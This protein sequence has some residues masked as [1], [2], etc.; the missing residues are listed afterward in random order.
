MCACVCVRVRMYT[1]TCACAQYVH[2]GACPQERACMHA[3]ACI[4]HGPLNPPTPTLM[5]RG[6]G[7]QGM[8]WRTK[9]WASW[10]TQAAQL[11]LGW[12]TNTSGDHGRQGRTPWQ[13]SRH[14]TCTSTCLPP[15]ACAPGRCRCRRC[16]RPT[17]GSC[18]YRWGGAQRRAGGWSWAVRG[19][20]SGRAP[21][22]WSKQAAGRQAGK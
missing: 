3:L 13:E 18:A 20:S 6:V 17:S 5:T 12:H 7:T 9:S 8:C 4:T 22:R 2:M 16:C 10:S 1:S 14:S 19:T 11:S 15:H 21:A